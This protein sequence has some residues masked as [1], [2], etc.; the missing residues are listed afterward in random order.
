VLPAAH[1]LRQPQAFASDR[2]DGWLVEGRVVSEPRYTDEESR[3]VLELHR[4]YRDSMPYVVAGGAL[5][6]DRTL[7]REVAAGDTVVLTVAL[8]R[9]PPARNPG[10]FDYR[11][12]LHRQGIDALATLKQPGQWRGRRS[13]QVKWWQNL[14]GGLRQ[15]M[16]RAL[17]RNLS[18]APAEL[19]LAMLLGEKYRLPDEV[20]TAF[21]AAGLSHALVVSGLHVG[22]VALFCLTA[23]RLCRLPEVW[24]AGLTVGFLVLFALVT[25]LQ[26]PVVRATV[27]AA[28]LLAGRVWGR[29]TDAYN[30]LGVA[31]LAL[32]I[33]R[34]V[35]CFELGFQLSFAATFSIIHLYGGLH[36]RLAVFCGSD[37]GVWRGWIGTWLAAPLGVS[38]AAQIGTA[39]LI[40][41]YFQQISLVAPLANLVAVPLMGAAVGLGLLACLGAV[42]APWAAMPFNGC[43]YLVL[44]A[45]LALAEICAALPWAS[46]AVGRPGWMGLLMFGAAVLFA[47]AVVARPRWRRPA[48]VVALAAA[49]LAVWGHVLREQ[50]L[51]VVFFDVGQGDAA[52]VRFPNGR[53]L[54]VDGGERNPRF[55]FGQRVLLPFLRQ[56]GIRRLDAVVGSHAHNDHIGGLV[57]LLEGVEVGYYL[58]S[59]QQPESSTAQALL[60]TAHR[61]GTR[62]RR[63]GAGDSLAGLGGVHAVVLHPLPGFVTPAGDSPHGLNNGSVVLR[64]RY[65]EVE[66]LFTGDIEKEAGAALL[67]WGSRLQSDVLKVAHHGSRTSSSSAFLAAVRPQLA[68]VSLGAYNRF[69][70]PAP[71]V[72]A[73]LDSVGARVVRTDRRGA[74]VLK[75]DGRTL[76]WETVLPHEEN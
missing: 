31:A 66:L 50:R 68:L 76:E 13:G 38:L 3:F 15:G 44:K 26:A 62:Y 58:D 57:A 71:Q 65:G 75:T 40:L 55:D 14:A 73:R 28:A 6:R 61:R 51:E 27:M 54:V 4:V 49:N 32:L 2:S 67:S 24:A 37:W 23:L 19:L 9:P 42:L 52:F 7:N 45:L 69:G 56:R 11:L 60:E 29:P 20:D 33:W 36:T 10:A 72:L 41:Y 17:L 46:V 48:L 25:D 63:V 5:V 16:R 18:G 1:I 39:P 47:P 12:H 53:T 22:L 59:G 64:L 35:W 34:P 8:R 21:R 30:A 43:N 74:L 70:H